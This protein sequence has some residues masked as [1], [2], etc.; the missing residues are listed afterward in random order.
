MKE[1]IEQI[2]LKADNCDDS[3]KETRA[4]KGAYVDCLMIVKEASKDSVKS[5]AQKLHDSFHI[6]SQ[7]ED[8]IDDAFE[9]Y[10]PEL[11]KK[12]SF[13][14][15]SDYYDNSIE[16]SFDVSIP[17][18]YE[19]S[20]E[21]RQAIYDIG[22]DIVYWNF[23]KDVMDVLCNRVTPPPPDNIWKDSPDEIRGWEPRHSK[24][25]IWT[26]NEYGYVDERFNQKEWESKY[27]FQKL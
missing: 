22:F 2:K 11:Y 14:I 18:P 9:K 13:H 24:H 5:V 7:V 6:Q 26:L 10:E 12:L 23:P 4:R 3:T 8:I 21:V 27:N 15:D 16:I 1:L 19:P 17:Y 20:K 25:A